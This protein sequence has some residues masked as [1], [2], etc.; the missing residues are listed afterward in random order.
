MKKYILYSTS[1]GSWVQKEA[2]IFAKE[3]SKTKGRG[4]VEIEVV[5]KIPRIRPPLY[6]DADGDLKPSWDWF[7]DQ[8]P[9][10]D[11]DGVI[12]HMTKYYRKKWKIKSGQ[13]G[14]IINGARNKDN[15]DYPEFWLCAEKGDM[16]DHYVDLPQLRRL[17]YHEHAHFDEDL[18]DQIGNVLAQ[19]SVHDFD[20]RLRRIDKYHYLVDYRGQAFKEKVNKLMNN[21]IKL[22]KKVI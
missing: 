17:L 1:G 7:K 20:Y 9:K 15:R 21:I 5:R 16:A 2:D 13:E 6:Y 19:G 10:Y 3:I 11:Y 22:V 4:D 12:F 8:F 14:F 18:D